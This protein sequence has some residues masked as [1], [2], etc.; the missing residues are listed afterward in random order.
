MISKVKNKGNIYNYKLQI[1]IAT[2][3][4]NN[5]IINAKDIEI[6]FL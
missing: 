4:Y 2:I 1:T 6:L 5:Q 3:L